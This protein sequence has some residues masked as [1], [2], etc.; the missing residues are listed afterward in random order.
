M[1][2]YLSL[3]L[4]SLTGVPEPIVALAFV[5]LAAVI[6]G[7]GLLMDTAVKLIGRSIFARCSRARARKRVARELADLERGTCDGLTA[8][9]IMRIVDE[10]WVLGSDRT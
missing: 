7:T 5:G 6:L 10:S 3:L 4:Q 8:V 9:Q 2:Q 1:T